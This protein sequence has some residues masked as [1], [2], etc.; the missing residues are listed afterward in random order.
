MESSKGGGEGQQ[1]PQSGHRPSKWSGGC[2]SDGAVYSASCSVRSFEPTWLEAAVDRCTTKYP[3]KGWERG[4]SGYET[5]QKDHDTQPLPLLA[6]S[7]QQTSQPPTGTQSKRAVARPMTQGHCAT[8]QPTR[9]CFEHLSAPKHCL[10]NDPV[11]GRGLVDGPAEQTA[12]RIRC[13]NSCS[14]SQETHGCARPRAMGNGCTADGLLLC[15]RAAGPCVCTAP[16]RC[17]AAVRGPGAEGK[18]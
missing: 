5:H 13:T 14:T 6:M 10:Q 9:N 3:N 16:G 12:A 2:L 18:R 8:K 1:H 17:N 15:R 11:V 4:G 7:K